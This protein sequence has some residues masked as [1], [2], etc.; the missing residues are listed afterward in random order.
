MTEVTERERLKRRFSQKA[1]DFRR[2][3]PSEIPGNASL[4][5]GAGNPV[6]CCFSEKAEDFG[7]K[8]GVCGR[9]AGA[10][11]SKNLVDMK[12]KSSS[13]AQFEVYV[14][15]SNPSWWAGLVPKSQN[16]TTTVKITPT[17]VLALPF[18]SVL[19]P[20]SPVSLL[21]SLCFSHLETSKQP[22]K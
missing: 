20:F 14:Y 8:L 2:F 12:A 13:G 6:F 1:T 21:L 17:H 5:E 11:R 10:S 19:R 15:G 9:E 18:S 16:S 4:W 3:G 7:R 22:S